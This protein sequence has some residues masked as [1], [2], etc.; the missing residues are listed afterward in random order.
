MCPVKPIKNGVL[1]VKG[2]REKEQR[3]RPF[4]KITEGLHSKMNEKRGTNLVEILMSLE[5]LSTLHLFHLNIPIMLNT[6]HF[7]LICK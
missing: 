1:G 6:K 2:G 7:D 3:L 5:N 4:K